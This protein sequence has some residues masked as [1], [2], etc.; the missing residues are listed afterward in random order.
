MIC[1]SNSVLRE[2]CPPPRPSS[3]K[4]GASLRDFL[5]PTRTNTDKQGAM[6]TDADRRRCK[7]DR[8]GEKSRTAAAFIRNPS[9]WPIRR[10]MLNWPDAEM[11]ES[12]D[13]YCEG[14]STVAGHCG[15]SR[16]FPITFVRTSREAQVATRKRQSMRR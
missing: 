4:D 2:S 6:Q 13:C 1:T 11:S 5:S 12:E 10:Q 16:V 9:Y 14:R 3:F 8:R 7:S 15:R